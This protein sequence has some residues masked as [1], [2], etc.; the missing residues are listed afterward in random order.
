MPNK[1]NIIFVCL[2]NIC[3]SPLADGLMLHHLKERGLTDHFHIDSAGTYAGH[4]GSRADE[5]MRQTAK[6]HGVELLSIARQFTVEDFDHFDYIVVMDDSNYQNV[7]R[8]TRSESDR[9]KVFKLRTYDNHQSNKDVEDPYYGG[10]Q[11]FENCFD[12]VDESVNNF[13]NDLVQQNN[14]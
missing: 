4:A 12:V 8:M 13:L 1:I 7:I 5:R 2:G 11:G 3:R 14:L 10:M 6:K 9:S